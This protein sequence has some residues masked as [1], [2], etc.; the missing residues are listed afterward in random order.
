MNKDGRKKGILRAQKRKI[1]AAKRAEEK[2]EAKLKRR[3]ACLN[4]C[5]ASFAR[6]YVRKPRKKK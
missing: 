6:V 2:A 5:Q 1:A 4:R 3:V